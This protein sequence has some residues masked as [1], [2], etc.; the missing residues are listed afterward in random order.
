MLAV[1]LEHIGKSLLFGAAPLLALLT[2]GIA[3]HYRRTDTAPECIAFFLFY[4]GWFIFSFIAPL[5][6][7]GLFD[8]IPYYHVYVILLHTAGIIPFIWFYC[9]AHPAA[10]K[11]LTRIA[12]AGFAAIIC[13]VTGEILWLLS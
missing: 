1:L 10:D 2:I 3:V 4:P 13:A 5:F 7:F 8:K 12:I 6:C 11:E 9:K